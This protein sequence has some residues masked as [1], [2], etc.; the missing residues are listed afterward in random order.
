VFSALGVDEMMQ[1]IKKT[2][3]GQEN[4]DNLK[5]GNNYK[6]YISDIRQAVNL[7][8]NDSTFRVTQ[9][10]DPASGCS[11]AVDN[12]DN[13]ILRPRDA[14]HLSYMQDQQ[15]KYI[16]T[17]DRNFDKVKTIKRVPF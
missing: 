15:I 4:A 14:F 17:N 9:F 3:Q 2:L 7:L 5:K 10:N 16:V 8:I 6:D 1:A 12:I 13:Y 11:H